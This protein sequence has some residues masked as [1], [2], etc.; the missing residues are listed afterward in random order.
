M[1]QP[2]RV[3]DEIWAQMQALGALGLSQKEIGNRVG[4]SQTTVS[5][6]FR[7]NGPA[8][9]EILPEGT[10]RCRKCKQV[11]DVESFWRHSTTKDGLCGAC[12]QCM[13]DQHKISRRAMRYRVR[14][15]YGIT[16]ERYDELK[17]ASPC[18]PICGSD[19]AEL[20]LDHDEQ[21]GKVREFLCGSCNRGLGM[22]YHN[23]DFLEAA[24]KY[25]KRHQ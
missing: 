14:K 22:F 8:P 18:C 19:S 10:K 16:L 4:L 21:T 25:L 2:R 11:K 20:N 5:K 24:I 12:R 1:P 6:H 15:V 3:T 17:A 9:Q 23:I 7:M 13:G